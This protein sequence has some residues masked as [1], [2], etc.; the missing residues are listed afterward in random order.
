MKKTVSES[1]SANG[2][3]ADKTGYAVN[4]GKNT[5]IYVDTGAV[6]FDCEAIPILILSPLSH[7]HQA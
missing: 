5:V 6:I 4:S 2:R 1:Y 7:F 3:C